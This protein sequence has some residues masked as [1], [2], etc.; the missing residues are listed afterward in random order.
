MNV[1]ARPSN[2]RSREFPIATR[3]VYRARYL[4]TTAGPPNGR[5]EYTTQSVAYSPR[6]HPSNAATSANPASLPAANAARRRATNL[7]R[8]TRLRTRTGRKN[9]GRHARHRPSGVSPPPVAMPW[10]WGW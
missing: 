9:P 6:T 8:N 7:P 1:T 10:A 5:C 3:W 2:A 4:S